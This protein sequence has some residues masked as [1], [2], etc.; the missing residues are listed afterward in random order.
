MYCTSQ[1]CQRKKF[2]CYLCG[3]PLEEKDHHSH[4]LGDPWGKTKMTCLT[5]EDKIKKGEKIGK[6]VNDKAAVLEVKLNEV[7]CPVC[8]T[9]KHDECEILAA[10]N[11]KICLCKK[12]GGKYYCIKCKKLVGD[13]D[14][15]DHMEEA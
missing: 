2:F 15:F 11:N 10:F 12:C 6:H 9:K 1:F 13:E 4:F 7:P 8:G 5:I 3:D 14:I